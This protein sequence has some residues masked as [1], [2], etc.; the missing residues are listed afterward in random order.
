MGAPM[1]VTGVT[2]PTVLIGGLPAA[3]QTDFCACVAPIPVPVDPIVMGTPVVLIGGLPAA[4]MGAPTAK[5]GVILPP[6]CPTVLVGMVGMAPP[7]ISQM[8][9]LTPGT[10]GAKPSNPGDM[11]KPQLQARQ[12]APAAQT[13]KA[14]FADR[15]KAI[16]GMTV[17]ESIALYKADTGKDLDPATVETLFTDADKSKELLMADKDL[18]T[19]YRSILNSNVPATK[20]EAKKAGYTQPSLLGSKFLANWYHDPWN[21][22]KWVS[23]DG[24]VEGV[25]D[26]N[27]NLVNTLEYKGTFNFFG[28]DK[29]SEHKKTDVDPYRKW[30]N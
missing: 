29:T 16:T 5:G 26:G 17:E 15:F 22:E 23:P 9:M 12:Q 1:P 25:Y 18:H 27:G 8:S 7:A 11:E 3:R 21:N 20:E 24:H 13:R 30:G 2:A 14:T 10:P 28:P 19:A 4:F 6:C